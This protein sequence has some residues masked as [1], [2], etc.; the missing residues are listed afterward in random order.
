MQTKNA[1]RTISRLKAR[2]S[3]RLAARAAEL[4]ND[5][6]ALARALGYEVRP[7]HRRWLELQQLSRR[8]LLLAPRGHGKSSVAGIVF[9]IWK[10]IQNPNV[11][12]LIVS[13]THDQAKVFL[14][15]IRAQIEQNTAFL[16]LFGDLRANRWSDAELLVRRTRIAKEATITAAGAN[17]VI[18]GRHFDVIIADD[19]IDE[20]NSWCETQRAKLQIWFHKTLF[21]CLEPDGE[22]HVIGTRYH[23]GDLYGEI[24]R[25]AQAEEEGAKGRGGEGAKRTATSEMPAGKTSRWA[26]LQD[27]AVAGGAPLWPEKFPIEHLDGLRSQMGDILFACQ[28]MND[29]RGGNSGIFQEQW[30][31]Y[32]ETLPMEPDGTGGFRQSTLRIFQGVD[33]AISQGPSA[34]FFAVVTIGVDTSHNVYVL[35]TFRGHLT[36]EKQLQKIRELAARFHPM[37]ID[38][39]S[40][41]YQDAL[42]SELV[43][44][45]GLP[46]RR[47]RQVRDKTLRA[48]KLS[49]QF[50]NG[51]IFLKRTMTDLVTELLL[52]P[53]APHDDLFD[54][55]EM[56]VSESI[57]TGLIEAGKY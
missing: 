35:D 55:L 22:I 25:R 48:I 47:V 13:N 38:V 29:P 56:A 14:R 50:E 41:A 4:R 12:I 11:R 34:D 44:T 7:F 24:V 17:G 43:R 10:V 21:P 16:A 27:C 37:R 30:L 3:K 52:F 2:L 51:K 46:V 18:V 5:P 1:A 20:E 8:S 53:R 39:E 54:A 33:L 31:Q 42:P 15:E 19:I 49:P 57:N 9:A 26:I 36:F 6:A 23:G 45:S 28:Y 40:N 32:Y